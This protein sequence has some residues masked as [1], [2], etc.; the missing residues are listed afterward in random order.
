LSFLNQNRYQRASEL[1]FQ[2]YYQAAIV[3]GAIFLQP[4]LSY[5]P[6][7]GQIPDNLNYT[8]RPGQAPNLSP[9][10]VGTLRLTGVF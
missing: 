5:I 1:M 7:P 4:T 3:P 9:A 8:P 2:T 10:V 6:T